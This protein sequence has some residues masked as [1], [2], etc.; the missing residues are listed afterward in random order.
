MDVLPV[1]GREYESEII[2]PNLNPPGTG[3]WNFNRYFPITQSTE[4][5]IHSFSGLFVLVS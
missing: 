3:F 4:G 5:S 1:P 2:V